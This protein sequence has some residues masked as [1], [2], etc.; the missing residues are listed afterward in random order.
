MVCSPIGASTMCFCLSSYFPGDFVPSLFIQTAVSLEFLVEAMFRDEF[1]FSTCHCHHLT[2]LGRAT[3]VLESL[4]V[5]G[6]LTASVFPRLVTIHTMVK[7][8]AIDHRARKDLQ[9]LLVAF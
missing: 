8:R 2:D 5:V 3:A 9:L 1:S 6:C 4:S 7:S